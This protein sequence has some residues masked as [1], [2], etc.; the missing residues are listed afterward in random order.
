[1]FAD[2][3]GRKLAQKLFETLSAVMPPRSHLIVEDFFPYF[4]SEAEAVSTLTSLFPSVILTFPQR[5]AFALFDKDGNGDI[6]KKEMREAVQRIY[7]ERKSLVA[8]LK[9]VT[10]A[11]AKLDAVLLGVTTL[12]V[13]FIC[14]LIF[15][16]QNTL[17]S[18]VPLAS[19]V[20]GFSFIFGHSAQLLFES[21]IFTFSTHTFDIGDLVMIDDMASHFG[22]VM[23]GPS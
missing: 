5:A 20:L 21:M 17:A 14:L 6:S 11:V 15:N 18:L 16:R 8:S 10:S 2:D 19:I 13:L 1:M 3:L 7:R 12:I 4:H 9:D 23:S 22:A